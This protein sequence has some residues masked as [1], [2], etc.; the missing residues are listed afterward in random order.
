MNIVSDI[1]GKGVVRASL[2]AEGAPPSGGTRY[3]HRVKKI[4]GR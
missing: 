1:S 3:T 2:L 4:R